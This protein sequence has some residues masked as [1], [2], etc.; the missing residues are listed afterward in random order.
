MTILVTGVAGFI[1]HA[2]ARAL[3]ARGDRVIGIDDL[4]PYYDPALKRA[5]LDDLGGR[6]DFTFVE[7]DIA[8]ADALSR[9]TDGTAIDRIVHLAAQ[10][11]VRHSIDNPH[12]YVRANMVG[13]LNVL[14]LARTRRVGHLVYASSSSVYGDSAAFPLSVEQRTDHPISLYAATKRA[15]ELMSDSYAH[16]YR[17]PQTGL[18]FFTVYGPWGRPDMAVWLFTSA[19]LDGRAIR[20]HAGGDMRRDFT[21]I[22]DIVAGV[23]AALDRPPADDGRPKPGGAVAPHAIYNLGGD[24]P[25]GVD[26]LVRLIEDACGRAAMIEASPMQPGDV[27]QTAA[28]ITASRRDL[29]FSPATPLDVGIPRFVDWFRHYRAGAGS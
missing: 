22:D 4:N 2:V 18:R 15:D 27:R 25:E 12:A 13:H 24:R 21:F 17:L 1:G 14:E 11:G 6:G 7:A 9:A 29:G 8:D 16:L 5:R 23:L 28:D 26:R 3:L 19:V 10:A 20:L